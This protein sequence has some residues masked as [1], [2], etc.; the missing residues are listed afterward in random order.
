MPEIIYNLNG[1]CKSVVVDGEFIYGKAGCL[2]EMFNDLSQRHPWYDK[3][4]E[5]L[6][7]NDFFNFDRIYIAV[8]SLIKNLL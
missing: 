1:C 7:A 2:S 3:G 8:A 5:T 4:Y 6:L